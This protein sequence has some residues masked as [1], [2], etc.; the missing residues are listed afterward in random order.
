MV[1]NST[2]ILFGIFNES[3]RVESVVDSLGYPTF[4][5]KQDVSPNDRMIKSFFITYF[6]KMYQFHTDLLGTLRV[7]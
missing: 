1:L 3:A 6:N 2:G 4:G 5:S 7:S